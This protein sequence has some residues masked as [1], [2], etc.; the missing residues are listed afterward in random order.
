MRPYLS[1]PW[2]W[3]LTC[4]A[5]TNAEVACLARLPNAWPFSG[6][7]IPLEADALRVLVVHHFNGVAVEDGDHRGSEISYGSRG[8]KKND[9]ANH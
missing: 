7:S 6:Q 3:S 5:K 4:F 1:L 8:R 2:V 9:K